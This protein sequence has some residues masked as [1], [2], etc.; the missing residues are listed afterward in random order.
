M[1]K[2]NSLNLHATKVSS[3]KCA[4]FPKI[5]VVIFSPL[6]QAFIFQFKQKKILY[7]IIYIIHLFPFIQ[8]T[9]N[10]ETGESGTIAQ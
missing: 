8:S 9:E 5:F 4:P 6:S 1:R 2:D 10:G 7:N 3:Y